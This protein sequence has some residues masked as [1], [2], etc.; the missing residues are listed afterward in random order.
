MV[1]K[2]IKIIIP[3]LDLLKAIVSVVLMAA[4]LYFM[5]K[6]VTRLAYLP[7]VLISAL[8][9]YVIIL[10]LIRAIN[11]KEIRFIIKLVK[12]DKFVKMFYKKY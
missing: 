7:L 11:N 3:Y 1:S 8:V 2:Y 5:L 6:I 9:F 4:F 12:A 10:Y